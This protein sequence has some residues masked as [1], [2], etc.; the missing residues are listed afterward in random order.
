[1]LA[2]VLAW[3]VGLGSLALY[4][5]AFFF[6]EVHRKQD[7][8]LSGVGM[9]YALVLWVCAGRITGGLLLGQM[10]GVGL[11]GWLGWETLSL[12]RGITPGDQQTALPSAEALQ[13]ALTNLAKP[14]VLSGLPGQLGSGLN[15]FVGRVQAAIAA[16]AQAKQS[17][18]EAVEAYVPLKREDFADA[19]REGAQSMDAA[20]DAAVNAARDQV[21]TVVQGVEEGGSAAVDSAVAGAEW[22]EAVVQ[23][24]TSGEFE[25]LST[26]PTPPVVIAPA[27]SGAAAGSGTSAGSALLGKVTGVIGTIAAAIPA[28]LQGLTKKKESQPIY[29]RK[30][31][32]R[33]AADTDAAPV[34]PPRTGAVVDAA[35]AVGQPAATSLGSATAVESGDSPLESESEQSESEQQTEVIRV[36]SAA[37]LLSVESPGAGLAGVQAAGTET[38]GAAMDLY[39]GATTSAIAPEDAEATEAATINAFA[40]AHEAAAVPDEV[41]VE[42]LKS[43]EYDADEFDPDWQDAEAV[44]PD[45]SDLPIDPPFIE[46]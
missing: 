27:G 5:A 16:G 9:F 19:A 28:L 43:D 36:E 25:A 23:P 2:Y 18:A 32:R 10:A 46:E 24:V 12:R 31:F 8:I 45:V 11:V 14:E 22:A 20:V 38:E 33:D 4:L 3:V 26:V 34:E 7:F 30:Q 35:I 42:V 41:G 15:Q 37:E 13:S 21:A 6:P 17:A 29:V 40:D 39:D 44:E 1:M